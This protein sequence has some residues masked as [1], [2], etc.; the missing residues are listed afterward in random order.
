MRP[1][2][3]TILAAFTLMIA[4]FASAQLDHVSY[5]GALLENGSP[6]NGTAS[7]KFVIVDG[8]GGTLWSHDGSS[9]SGAEP[10]GSI[11]IAV[12]RGVFSVLLGKNMLALT[13]DAF[14]GTTDPALR[15]WVDSGAGFLQ[16]P[17]QPL[18]SSA[19]ALQ[20]DGAKRAI[21]NFQVAGELQLSTGIRFPDNSLQVTAGGSGDDGDWLIRGDSMYSG[22]SGNVGIGTSSPLDRLHV[23]GGWLR[24]DAFDESGSTGLRIGE[25]GANR[26]TWLFKAWQDDDLDLRDET[27]GFD[28]LTFKAGTRR[29]GVGIEDPGVRLDVG[30]IVRVQGDTWP[31]TGKGVELAYNPTAH[32]AFLQCF[33][34]DLSEWGQLYL[35]NGQVGVGVLDPNAALHVKGQY[36]NLNTTEGDFKIGNDNYRMKFGVAIGGAGAGTCSIRAQGG[37]NT[38]ALG[39]GDDNRLMIKP[40]GVEVVNG[41]L[42]TPIITI[43]GGADIAEP[44]PVN[45]ETGV[46]AGSV[47]VIDASDPG[48][49][50][51]SHS[52]YDT[53]V[54]GVVSGAGGV[55]PGLTLSQE[56]MFESGEDVAL[57]GRVYVRATTENGPIRPGDLLTTSSLAGHAMRATDRDRWPG[58]VLGKAMGLL[59]NGE[60][61]VLALVNLQ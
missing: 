36:W 57:N 32:R 51:L 20:S 60:G 21:G 58:A 33:D 49:L 14:H 3:V 59:E 8:V 55:N 10:A 31:S 44:F 43:T 2:S 24:A 23:K 6:F 16:L 38:L 46:E 1:L 5:Q 22:V 9:T 28:L 47:L 30:D 15:V 27:S 53:R 4:S 18:S 7:F 25:G 61:L 40:T 52:P 39:G 13:A 17:D 41:T 54:A 11:D 29:I 50:E 42:T 56:D 26:W 35:G 19:F 37:T 45:S 12:D 48:N 34:R